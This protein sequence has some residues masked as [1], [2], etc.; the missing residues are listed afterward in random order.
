MPS[1]FLWLCQDPEPRAECFYDSTAVTLETQYN[2]YKNFGADFSRAI[3]TLAEINKR[4]YQTAHEKFRDKGGKLRDSWAHGNI[5][6]RAD[7]LASKDPKFKVLAEAYEW[8]YKTL[9][10]YEHSAPVL[11]FQYLHFSPSTV[12]GRNTDNVGADLASKMGQLLG[13]LVGLMIEA[14]CSL[15]VISKDMLRFGQQESKEGGS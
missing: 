15:K 8:L 7:D 3:D 1:D 6:N 9:S 5:R 2:R 13:V 11:A 12:H 14:A 10:D 4:H